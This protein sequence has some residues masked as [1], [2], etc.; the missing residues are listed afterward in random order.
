MLDSRG[1]LTAAGSFV[2]L[3]IACGE[4]PGG[5]GSTAQGSAPVVASPAA[6]P[7][8]PREPAAVSA[9]PGQGV[10]WSVV[11][12]PSCGSITAG[13]YTAPSTV[14][15]G[16]TCHVRVTSL[17]SSGT[18]A[19]ATVT[20][21]TSITPT[22]LSAGCSASSAAPA[23]P[24]YFSEVFGTSNRY[25]TYWVPPTYD[26]AQPTPLPL[27]FDFH[28]L[29]GCAPAPSDLPGNGDILTDSTS[30]P[31]IFV[32]PQGLYGDSQKAATP[33]QGPASPGQCDPNAGGGWYGIGQNTGDCSDYDFQFLDAIFKDVTSHFCVDLNRVYAAGF[34]FGADMTEGAAC[35]YGDHIRAIAPRGG[36]GIDYTVNAQTGAPNC[37]TRKWPAAWFLFDW[38][39][40]DLND[41]QTGF[42]Y[43]LAQLGCDPDVS[44]ATAMNGLC[45]N[46]PLSSCSTVQY[47][48][49]RQPL[50][51]TRITGS[52]YGHGFVPDGY[53]RD[54]W[55]FF[56]SFQ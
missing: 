16:G 14:P 12:G 44:H 31:G 41:Y 42:L 5:R 21:A 39:G 54:V 3:A 11:E 19:E 30:T 13:L 33:L 43:D 27:V 1:A 4:V 20:V 22:N 40:D 52:Q 15:A 53:S 50:R 45:E 23:N 26:P 10:T 36:G 37:A 28:W 35:C 2:C 17:A 32:Y 55:S 9:L 18:Y 34:S 47:A 8:G 24:R 51:L 7:L 46:V 48:Q 49:C 29:G 25:Y 38:N 6:V 56:N